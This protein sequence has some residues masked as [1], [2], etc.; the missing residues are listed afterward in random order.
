MRVSSTTNSFFIED[1]TASKNLR[2]RS[3]C[4]PTPDCQP[5]SFL[6]IGQSPRGVSSLACRR[7]SLPATFQIIVRPSGIAHRSA[8]S[9]ETKDNRCR[10]FTVSRRRKNQGLALHTVN[11]PLTGGLA[12]CADEK[13]GRLN[14]RTIPNRIEVWRFMASL[15]FVNR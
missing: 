14:A 4:E 1:S 7:R 12:V 6:P 15:T 11:V 2:S 3:S 5:V 8:V 10:L 9:V 13:P